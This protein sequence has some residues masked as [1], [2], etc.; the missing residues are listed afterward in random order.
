MREQLELP[1]FIESENIEGTGGSAHS[2]RTGR[3]T[4]HPDAR[5]FRFFL[6]QAKDH[7]S[8]NVTLNDVIADETRVAGPQAA[9]N[10]VLGLERVKLLV[11]DVNDFDFETHSLQVTHPA[12]AASSR[13]ALVDRDRISG[14]FR[15]FRKK[16]VASHNRQQEPPNQRD[17]L[18]G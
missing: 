13:R 12:G 18:P 6:Q 1:I 8:R 14:R 10:A 3:H 11:G 4:R 17:F 7:L 9:G 16:R 15:R 5:D 2:R